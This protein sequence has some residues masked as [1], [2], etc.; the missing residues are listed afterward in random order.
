MAGLL[1][2]HH[3]QTSFYHAGLTFEERNER[4]D[5]WIHNRT[6]VIVS[7]NAFGMGI[8]K[9]DVRVVIHMDIPPNLES[10][11]Q[12]AG[13]AGRDEKK[14]F[15]VMVCNQKD[16][17]DLRSRTSQSLPEEPFLRAIYQMLG[18]H[19]QL[20]IGS[21]PQESLSFDFEDFTKHFDQKP[22]EV[23]Q[24]L[25]SLESQGFIVL[26]EA[27]YQ[28]SKAMFKIDHRELYQFQIANGGFDPLIK[29]LLRLHGGELYNAPTQVKE[30]NLSALL[31]IS[32]LESKTLLRQLHERDVLEYFEQ[33]DKPQLTFLT[34]RF[35]MEELP[36]DKQRLRAKRKLTLEKMESVIAYLHNE[37]RCRT[38]QLLEYFGEVS[39]DKCGVCDNCIDRK[40][41]EEE[42]A[43]S[44]HYRKQIEEL[45]R[46][47]V[48]LDLQQLIK[49]LDPEKKEVFSNLVAELLDH[50]ILFYDDFGKMKPSK[51]T[52]P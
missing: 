50:G 33:K 35:A 1:Q 23:F 18:N 30:T 44:I 31:G 51:G 9:P 28:P 16:I 8:D 20:A 22:T 14:A 52:N 41:R 24:G 19:F 47:E 37:D 12:E 13:R 46:Q 34:P 25:K 49:I 6:R 38:Q 27:F 11:Y 36:I 42:K 26:T 45:L 15:G 4:Q 5:D 40:R 32:L 39:Y 17:E 29:G 3:I 48:D 43:L 10:Y 2:R 21:H 7:T